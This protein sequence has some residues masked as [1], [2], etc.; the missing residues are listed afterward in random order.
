MQSDPVKNKT[1]MNNTEIRTALSRRY[2]N[3]RRSRDG[4][5]TAKD[6]SARTVLARRKVI[7]I[8]NDEAAANA[9]ELYAR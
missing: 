6:Y 9:A 7:V 8:G 5:W 2:S 3:V 1:T 4:I